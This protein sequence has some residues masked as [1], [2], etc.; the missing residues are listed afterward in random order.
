MR[1]KRVHTWMKE[2]AGEETGNKETNAL[3][4][5]FW[6]FVQL[7]KLKEELLTSR[8]FP[9]P[10]IR[11]HRPNG[12]RIDALAQGGPQFFLSL[13]LSGQGNNWAGWI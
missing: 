6:L 2:K 5:F 12:T 13:D 8:F 7:K 4:F 9:S 11:V 10:F 3:F 1:L